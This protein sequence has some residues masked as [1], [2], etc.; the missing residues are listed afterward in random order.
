MTSTPAADRWRQELASWAI[1]DHIRNAAPSFPYRMDPEL[2][3]PNPVADAHSLATQRA[4]DALP[5]DLDGASA[6]DIGCGGGAAAMALADRLRSVT[7]V[8]QS[9]EML[10]LFAEEAAARGLACRTIQ[11]TWPAPIAE[12]GKADVVLCHHVAY[13]VA[14]LIRFV[15]GL[16]AVAERRVVMELTLTHPQ[17]SNA[18]LWREFWDLERPSGPT[19]DDAVAVIREAGID[20]TTEIG[21][22]GSLRAE[23]PLSAR[24]VTAARMLCLGPERLDEVER[25]I[26]RLPPRSQDR[27]VIWWDSSPDRDRRPHAL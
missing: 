8:D 15:Q 6:L 26:S 10:A 4:L 24:S 19:A 17:T 7:G 14:D 1:P 27:A 11:G 18:P 9:P 21:G 20:A 25:A 22:A 16:D 2:F 23:A 5:P 3:R 13:N 12:A